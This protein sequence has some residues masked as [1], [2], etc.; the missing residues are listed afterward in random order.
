[1]LFVNANLQQCKRAVET[2]LLLD[3]SV[4]C[5]SIQPAR[6][7]LGNDCGTAENTRVRIPYNR[8]LQGGNRQ[9]DEL[10]D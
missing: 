10:S 2:R 7:Q 9:T 1:M 3:S 6:G 4:S 8:T 5:I